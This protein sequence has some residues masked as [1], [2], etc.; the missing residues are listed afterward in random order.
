MMGTESLTRSGPV[1]VTSEEIE[2]GLLRI[3]RKWGVP[4]WRAQ[5]IARQGHPGLAD[6]INARSQRD[7]C[8]VAAEE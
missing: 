7:G 2:E 6:R 3:F 8:R 1:V 5:A 4:E